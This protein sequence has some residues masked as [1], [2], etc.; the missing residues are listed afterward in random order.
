MLHV[1][2]TIHNHTNFLQEFALTVKDS[3]VFLFSGMRLS[4]FRVPPNKDLRLRFTLLPLVAGRHALPH[5]HVLSKRYDKELP[6][7]KLKR[8]VYVQPT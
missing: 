7:T 6:Q 3:D 4:A 8:F 5:F 1:A 2:I